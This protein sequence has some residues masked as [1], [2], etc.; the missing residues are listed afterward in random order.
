MWFNLIPASAAWWNN[1][2]K[3]NTMAMNLSLIK[4][5]P[6]LKILECSIFVEKVILRDL[7]NFRLVEGENNLHII[8]QDAP[9]I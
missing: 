8:L 7:S 4:Y 1:S 3:I 9:K 2:G 5:I 6:F